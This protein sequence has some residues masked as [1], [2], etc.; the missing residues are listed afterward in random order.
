MY[1]PDGGCMFGV[2]PKERWARAFP[3][4]SANRIALSLNCYVAETGGHTIV[5]DTGGGV[6]TDPD[7]PLCGGLEAP[8][9]IA[10]LLAEAGM[11]PLQVDIVINSHLHWDHCG[12][13]MTDR[14]RQPS[15]PNAQYYCSRAEWQ[16][17]QELNPR[18]AVSYD[19][20]NFHALTQSGQMR[21]VA[22]DSYEPAPGVRMQR[23]P[24]HTRDLQLVTLDSGAGTFCFLSDLV[25]TTAHLLPG[26]SP[27]FDLYPLDTLSSKVRWLSKAAAEHWIC[28]FAHD[29]KVAFGVI[30]KQFA[31]VN[32]TVF[33]EHAPTPCNALMTSGM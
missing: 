33:G 6:R 26:W 21:L 11:D 18:D 4:N 3:A 25:P 32:Q 23:V 16:H 10:D 17:A 5:L 29:P 20:R 19:P 31:L 14:G 9:A 22:E 15:F 7:A 2:V 28:G 24:G 8:L 27:A 30:N 12:G 1:Y 13:N